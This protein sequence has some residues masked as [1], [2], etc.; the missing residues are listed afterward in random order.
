MKKYPYFAPLALLLGISGASAE[1]HPCPFFQTDIDALQ[2]TLNESCMI[3]VMTSDFAAPRYRA[4]DF[5]PDGALLVFVST[6]ES[7]QLSKSTGSRVYFTAPRQKEAEPGILELGDETVTIR[8]RAGQIARFS[9]ATAQLVSLE[10][11]SVTVAAEILLT[12]KSGVEIQPLE[13][14]LLIDTDWKTGGTGYDQNRKDKP[15]FIRDGKGK[16]CTVKNTDLFAYADGEGRFK[17]SED[18]A[19]EEFLKK[20]CPALDRSSLQTSLD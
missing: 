12:N 3:S 4:Y 18:P 7:P 14:A 16:L 11:Y 5:Y 6:D 15:S 1:P 9:R 10:G 17:F 2:V 19:L 13:G 20:K 8:S